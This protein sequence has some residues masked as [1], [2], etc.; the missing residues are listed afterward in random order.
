MVGLHLF[1]V[2]SLDKT[3]I[4][5]GLS[6]HVSHFLVV[7]LSLSLSI[8][9]FQCDIC[10]AVAVDAGFSRDGGFSSLSLAHD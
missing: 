1:L 5:L 4:A 2:F 8:Y 6:P 3:F 7:C 9:N 10:V